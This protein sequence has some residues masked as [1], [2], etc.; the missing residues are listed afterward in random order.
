MVKCALEIM[1][2]HAEK[3]VNGGGNNFKE[4]RSCVITDEL[5]IITSTKNA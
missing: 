4:S 3:I 2:K 1:K 5:V